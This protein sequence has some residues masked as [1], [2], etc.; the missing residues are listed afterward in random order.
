MKEKKS[1]KATKNFLLNMLIKAL[2][3]LSIKIPPFH[4]FL[5]PQKK[6][7]I[8]PQRVCFSC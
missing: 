1:A 7:Q 8:H 2:N 6:H 5:H 4:P 3:N